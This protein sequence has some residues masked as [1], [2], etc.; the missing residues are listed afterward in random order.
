MAKVILT[1]YF[2][3]NGVCYHGDVAFWVDPHRFYLEVPN[4]FYGK[5]VYP[6]LNAP[7]YMFYSNGDTICAVRQQFAPV[8]R[9]EIQRFMI[10]E[11]R[12]APIDAILLTSEPCR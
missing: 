10:K 8:F 9:I 12:I 4:E 7:D 3:Y 1:L 11:S 2:F 5:R 6:R